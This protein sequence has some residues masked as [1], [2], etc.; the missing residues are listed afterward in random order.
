MLP[1]NSFKRSV[2]VNPGHT[3][4]TRT[5]YGAYS[6]DSVLTRPRTADRTAFER[7]RLVTGCSTA[8]EVIVIRRPHC[9]SFIMGRTWRAKKT[10]LIKLRSTAERQS[11]I[12]VSANGLEGG[13]P[14]LVTQ[15]STRPN[16]S[17]TFWTNNRT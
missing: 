9:R 10:V 1:R 2:A 16:F 15:M 7:T 14:A 6:F 3:L 17:R 13:P 8:T 11:S 5:L 12:E 4:F